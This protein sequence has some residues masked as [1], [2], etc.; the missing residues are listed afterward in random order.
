MVPQDFGRV[1][2]NLMGNAFDTVLE[3][4]AQVNGAYSPK[5]TVLT[6]RTADGVEVRAADNDGPRMS[7]DVKAKVFEPFLTTKP[8]GSGMGLGLSLSTT[9]SRRDMASATRGKAQRL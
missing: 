7:D 2:L 4:A 3:Q 8:T 5:I 9:S 6:Q 1:I